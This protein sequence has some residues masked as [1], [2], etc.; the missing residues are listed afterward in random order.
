MTTD[1]IDLIKPAYR[2]DPAADEF[3]AYLLANLPN[4]PAGWQSAGWYVWEA[5][6]PP[7]AEWEREA[8]DLDAHFADEFDGE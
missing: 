8:A 2:T 3:A 1:A 5:P 6:I 4:L 7:R